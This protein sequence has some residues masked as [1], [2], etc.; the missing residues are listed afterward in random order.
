VRRSWINGERSS[1]AQKRVADGVFGLV[2]EVEVLEAEVVLAD[3][4]EECPGVAEQVGDGRMA[5]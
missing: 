5:Y 4:A 3:S 2:E 1:I